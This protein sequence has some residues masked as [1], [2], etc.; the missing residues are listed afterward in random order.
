MAISRRT[1][2]KYCTSSAAV[3]GL[4]ASHLTQLAQALNSPTGP[5]VLWLQ[6]AGCTGCSV[7]FLDHISS[8][9]PHDAGEVLIDVINLAYHPNIM[10]AAGQTAV[11]SA[12]KALDIGGYVLVVEGG[13]PTIF[14]GNACW[15]WTDRGKDVTFEEAVKLYASKAAAIVCMGQCSS[16]GGLFAAPPNPTGIKSVK[17]LTGKNTINVA[18][19]PP[20]PDWL[21]SVVAKLVAGI[22]INLDKYGRPTA[23]YKNRVHETCP[24]KGAPKTNQFGEYGKCLEDVGC[25]GKKDESKAPCPTNMFN[26]GVNFCTLAGAPCFGCTNPSFPGTKPFFE[27]D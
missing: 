17:E 8:I 16:Y 2:F 12:K 11:N 19:C 7:S 20:H 14:N 27:D 26:G 6:G 23:I 5:T 18:G 13:I 25:R 21:V 3:L 9:A 15:A 24:L 22:P 10:A 4:S 1:F